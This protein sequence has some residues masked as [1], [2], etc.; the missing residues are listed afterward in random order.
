M[1]VSLRQL[2]RPY[3]ET[4]YEDLPVEIQEQVAKYRSREAWNSSPPADRWD[5]AENHDAIREADCAVSTQ[6]ISEHVYWFQ[7]QGEILDTERDIADLRLMAE[8]DASQRDG[9]HTQLATLQTK[10][11]TLHKRWHAPDDLSAKAQLVAEIADIGRAPVIL[12]ISQALEFL[13]ESTAVA[14]TE[15]QLLALVSRS[16][17]YLYADV[18]PW[19]PLYVVRWEEYGLR[20]RPFVKPGRTVLAVL[21]SKQVEEVWVSGQAWSST[22]AVVEPFLAG[23]DSIYL[24]SP[25]KVLRRDIRLTQDEALQILKKWQESRQPIAPLGA[26]N[27]AVEIS[28]NPSL[29]QRDEQTAARATDVIDALVPEPLN[30]P[31][32]QLKPQKRVR[33]ALA[34]MIHQTLKTALA[35]GHPLPRAR[36][37]MDAIASAGFDDFI[38]LTRDGEIKFVGNDGNPDT[39][40]IEEIR[41]RIN[42]MTTIVR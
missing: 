35:E 36:Q 4:S 13:S 1:Y 18:P 31:M 6:I 23:G 12:N 25:I 5:F 10:L 7:L 26:F 41:S 2:F 16:D 34:T 29:G 38:E 30:G 39:A 22:T 8:R 33:D 32:W 3:L 24:E 21:S 42:R 28:N 37:V 9:M 20:Q 27:E 11:T 17:I 19:T 14:W 40:D 15:A